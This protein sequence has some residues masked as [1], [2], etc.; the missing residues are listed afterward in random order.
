MK[1]KVLIRVRDSWQEKRSDG[2]PAGQLVQQHWTSEHSVV[3]PRLGLRHQGNALGFGRTQVPFPG[4]RVPGF[5]TPIPDQP[6]HVLA[7]VRVRI[8]GIGRG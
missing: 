3:V 2:V 5:G 8:K 7:S 1:I 6:S 4:L